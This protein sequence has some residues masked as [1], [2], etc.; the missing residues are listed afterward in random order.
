MNDLHNS[1]DT[2]DLA[3]GYAAILTDV[4]ATYPQ[5]QLLWMRDS[6]RI[7]QQ[8]SER[9]LPFFTVELPLLEKQLLAGLESGR[10]V[11]DGLAH[12]RAT[13]HGSMIP[14]LF[15]GLW[16]RI[17][18]DDGL[19]L[20]EVDATAVWFLRTLLSGCKK[21][22]VEYP[23]H[24]LYAKTKEFYDAEASLPEAPSFWHEY[25]E[26]NRSRLGHLL[27]LDGTGG[28]LPLFG[29]RL[30]S[31]RLSKLLL[32]C[33][34]VADKV[35]A[36]LGYFCPD[37]VVGKHGPGA[38]AS[39][40]AS[41]YKYDFEFWQPQLENLF[42]RD[43]FAFANLSLA[44]D[45]AVL[46]SIV[47]REEAS[48]LIPVPKDHRGPR[49][50]AAEPMAN[51]WMQQGVANTLRDRITR[52]CLRHCLDFFSQVPSQV[53]AQV[54]ART[55]IACT[56]DLAAASD[57]LSA[58]VVQ[59]IFRA[60][61]SLLKMLRATRTRYLVQSVDLKCDNLIL[62]RKFATM[63]SALT[64]PLQSIVFSI[65]LI[66]VGKL[67][68]PTKSIDALARKIRVFG[69][70]LIAPKEWL[71]D[72]ELT[73]ETL[74]LRVNR[75][76]TFSKGNFR[77]SCGSDSLSG[78][79]VTP[80]YFR[81]PKALAC[82]PDDV[83]SKLAAANNL[84]LK[85]LWHT[86]D[87]MVRTDPG[88]SRFPVVSVSSGFTGLTTFTNGAPYGENF[89]E[90]SPTTAPGD[91]RVHEGG[92]YRRRIQLWTGIGKRALPVRWSTHLQRW[93]VRVPAFFR[94][95]RRRTISPV[96]SRLLDE[97]LLRPD[98]RRFEDQRDRRDSSSDTFSDSTWVAPRGV[99]ILIHQPL[100]CIHS[101][102]PNGRP[103]GTAG[104]ALGY[105]ST[106]VPLASLGAKVA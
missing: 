23:R 51:Q 2:I 68:H 30:G 39:L 46:D 86:A 5:D 40:P 82:G 29:R 96:S 4:G 57:R 78:T 41:K 17:F 7:K 69:D 101:R 24:T 26:P 87:W 20:G 33:Q 95:Q 79:D 64:F 98:S 18:S 67:H 6:K 12:S 47:L 71:P 99:D 102:G 27:D 13:H 1:L 55:G 9:G 11:L 75:G 42:E 19:L 14:R 44:W 16:M 22:N 90:A 88:I 61:L 52:T 91:G 58:Y 43:K 85:G 53:A 84:F 92:S 83:A 63:G 31:D 76:K 60:N 73:L 97:F 106:W 34:Q 72:I 94:K 59:R 70:D 77:E 45:D 66:G 32:S 89:E 10:L 15:Q 74:G 21:L 56:I 100:G 37:E 81:N 93:E 28:D 62:L 38:V 48:R 8:S 3:A 103:V 49:L 35:S 36:S 65:V 54:A 104:T 25:E 80:F 105:R 50:I